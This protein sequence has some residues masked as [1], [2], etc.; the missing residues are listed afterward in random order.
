M[1]D[2][3]Q[4]NSSSY[5]ATTRLEETDLPSPTPPSEPKKGGRGLLYVGIGALL[6]ILIGAGFAVVLGRTLFQG[7]RDIPQ[8]VSADTQLYIS[9]TPNLS[10]VEGV[11]RLKAAYP[12]LFIEQDSSSLD[13]DLKEDLG[14][15]FK[16][17]ILPWLGTEMSF[18]I[19]GIPA[20]S[21]LD[22][23]DDSTI[24]D[25][26]DTAEIALILTSR[27]DAAAKAFLDKQRAHREGL[28]DSF[29]TTEAFGR[30]IYEKTEG[31]KN[32][33]SAFTQVDGYI[34]FGNNAA[35]L[36]R[37]MELHSKGGESLADNPRFKNVL[38]DL[39][40]KA[41]FYAFMDGVSLN[42]VFSE[43]VQASLNE[44]TFEQR[45]QFEDQLNN[46]KA[47]QGMGLSISIDPEGL[48]F[49]TTVQIDAGKLSPDYAAQLKES[50]TGTDPERLK[51]ISKDALG[52]ITFRLPSTFKDQVMEAMAADGDIEETLAE[53]EDQIGINL[54]QDILSWM[55]GDVSLVVLPGEQVGDISIPVTG[56]ISIRPV[57]LAAAERGMDKIGVVL[58]QLANSQGIELE[59]ETFNGVL[60][61]VVR[62]PMDDSGTSLGGYGFAGPELVFAVGQH[63]L[64]T[65]GGPPNPI[66]DEATFKLATGKVYTPNTGLFYINTDKI[67]DV[68]TEFDMIDEDS[69]GYELFHPIQAVTASG[70]PGLDD[71]GAVRAR[72]FILLNGE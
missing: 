41:V 3:Q 64:D 13:E 34:L 61:T 20:N 35:A 46:V 11:Q 15:T 39:P 10:A 45:A 9:L 38:A 65:A 68:L 50:K 7:K 29:T 40:Q 62:S 42:E 27:D 31:E 57:D 5:Y 44:M 12:K 30:T 69:E 23:L 71:K 59:E 55:H 63:A 70:T 6:V 53:I 43:A 58:K 47:L 54:E 66:S 26:L 32:P 24:G 37:I 1:S 36:N 51:L 22:D 49:D 14:V 60:W 17:D 8:I 56:F 33:L 2:P 48:Q 18:V 25:M 67:E 4:P 16:E 28:G 72:L 52:L 21:Q 19:R